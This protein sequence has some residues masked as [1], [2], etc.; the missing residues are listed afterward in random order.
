[1]YIIANMIKDLEQLAIKYQKIAEYALQ[2]KQENSMLYNQIDNLQQQLTLLVEDK[3]Q[4]EQRNAFLSNQLKHA[5]QHLLGIIDNVYWEDPADFSVCSKEGSALYP[6]NSNLSF[7]AAAA[8]AA[9]GIDDINMS[10]AILEENNIADS[11]LSRAVSNLE[12]VQQ[13][14]SMHLDLHDASSMP[15]LNIQNNDEYEQE[16][17]R[18]FQPGLEQSRG[19]NYVADNINATAHGT[20][21]QQNSGY[22][23]NNFNQNADLNSD[24][25]SISSDFPEKVNYGMIKTNINNTNR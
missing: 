8:A 9:I 10:A 2:L 18:S 1:M 12:N 21:K 24:A 23:N 6:V 3:L 15:N 22:V 20:A 13:Q 14:I 4:L 5:K 7:A 19:K 11:T 17:I 16:N 25:V